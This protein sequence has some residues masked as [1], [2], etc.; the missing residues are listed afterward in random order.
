MQANSHH[1]RLTSLA[2]L[3][4]HIECVLEM[5][6]E[7]ARITETRPLDVELEIIAVV[8]VRYHETSFRLLLLTFEREVNPVWHIIRICVASPHKL[9]AHLFI[10]LRD[11]CAAVRR[12]PT[13]VPSL[14]S[15]PRQ[16]L[17]AFNS[18]AD[19]RLLPVDRPIMVINPAISVGCD[20]VAFLNAA[21]RD[22]GLLL[23]RL[24]DG[25]EGELHLM[26]VEHTEEAP[27]ADARTILILR[28]GVVVTLIDAGDGRV[29]AEVRLVNAIAIE[30]G[31]LAALVSVR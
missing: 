3:V 14:G 13:V 21:R 9:L 8:A 5:R 24:G 27:E 11:E 16:R 17:E 19:V 30:N 25:I 4:Q 28:F 29:L 15:I 23:D 26:I 31:T 10:H 6:E 2:L 20:I 1:L 7:A 12:R 22:L 18:L